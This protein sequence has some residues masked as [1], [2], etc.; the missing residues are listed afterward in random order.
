MPARSGRSSGMSPEVATSFMPATFPPIVI[1]DSMIRLP[2]LNCSVLENCLTPT[3][4]EMATYLNDILLEFVSSVLLLLG[5][6]LFRA[7]RSFRL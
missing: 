5:R 3:L 1:A 6:A 7:E 4:L 2:C